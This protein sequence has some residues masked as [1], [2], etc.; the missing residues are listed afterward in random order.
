ML[1]LETLSFCSDFSWV[2]SLLIELLESLFSNLFGEL[3]KSLLD[4]D[5]ETSLLFSDSKNTVSLL[6]GTSFKEVNLENHLP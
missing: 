1:P 3:L 6:H 4:S 2:S 5:I